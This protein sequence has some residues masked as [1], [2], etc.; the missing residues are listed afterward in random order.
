MS[1]RQMDVVVN[2][3]QNGNVSFMETYKINYMTQI[4]YSNIHCIMHERLPVY[5][6]WKVFKRGSNLPGERPGKYWM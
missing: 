1:E 3:V 2:C 6:C 5:I 4:P